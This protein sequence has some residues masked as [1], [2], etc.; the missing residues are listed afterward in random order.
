MASCQSPNV[1]TS[2]GGI[3]RLRPRK[4]PSALMTS[5]ALRPEHS[6]LQ[7]LVTRAYLRHFIRTFEF[8]HKARSA[9]LIRPA[10]VTPDNLA[11]PY[12]EVRLTAFPQP[13]GRMQ[14]HMASRINRDIPT[15]FH[16]LA[17]RVILNIGRRPIRK[18]TEYGTRSGLCSIAGCI[19]Y[20][21]A[22]NRPPKGN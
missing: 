5:P 9:R 20:G 6:E 4:R 17:T 10:L 13:H 18:M 19:L 3:A 15:W 7:Q 8:T 1:G 16:F 22:V 12:P 11:G 2:R 14:G 21:K